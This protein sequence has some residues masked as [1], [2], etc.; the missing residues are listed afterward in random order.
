MWLEG[1]EE[2]NRGVFSHLVRDESTGALKALIA[3]TNGE[4][5]LPQQDRQDSLAPP[6][7]P[8]A[9]NGR[10]ISQALPQY[11]SHNKDIDRSPM[12]TTGEASIQSPEVPPPMQIHNGDVNGA[13]G[14]DLMLTMPDTL[15]GV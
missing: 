9:T 8:I 12:H 15:P 11:N 7:A 6:N 2:D 5:L 13:D 1:K 14:M 3:E 10:N 4:R